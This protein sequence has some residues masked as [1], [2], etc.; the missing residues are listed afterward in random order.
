MNARDLLSTRGRRTIATLLTYMEENV[1]PQLPDEVQAE[2]Q[3]AARAKI[4][5]V[6]GDYQDL[7]MDLIASEDATINEFWVEELAKLH[8]TIGRLDGHPSKIP[9]SR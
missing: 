7:A 3:T 4:L 2:V 9:S 8:R 5:A 6:L 1:W